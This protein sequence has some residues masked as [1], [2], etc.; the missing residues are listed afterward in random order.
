MLKQSLL[1]IIIAL[2]LV[3]LFVLLSYPVLKKSNE[4][5]MLLGENKNALKKIY[6]S[7][8]LPSDDLINSMQQDNMDLNNKYNEL[9]E[10]LPAAKESPPIPENTN[11]PLFFLKELKTVKETLA[12]RASGGGVQILDEN[13]GLPNT[14]PSDSEAIHLIEKLYLTKAIVDLLIETRVNS[15]SQINLGQVVGTDVYEDVPLTLQV[16]CDVTSLAHLLF[17]LENSK[18]CFFIVRDF[19]FTSLSSDSASSITRNE[20][21][22]E[23][24]KLVQVNLKLSVIK[25]K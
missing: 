16:N 18:E 13:L 23:L 10:R 6:S 4:A 19:E 21:S 2:V 8:N 20:F 3:L 22:S 15:I 9:K 24:R 25:W 14:L 11:L 7:A 1:Y 12:I 5:K 17:M